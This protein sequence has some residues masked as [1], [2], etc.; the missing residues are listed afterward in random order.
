MT[1]RPLRVLLAGF[2]GVGRE[3]ARILDRRSDHPGLAGADL[4]LVAITTGRHGALAEPRGIDPAEALAAY[5]RGGF[6]PGDPGFVALDTARAVADLDYDVLVDASPLRIPERGEPAISWLRTALGRGHHAVTCNKGPVAWAHREL[7]TLAR[8]RGAAFRFESTVMDGVPVFHLARCGL[9]GATVERLEGILNSTTNVVL[10]G[11][12]AGLDL[13][14][15]VAGAQ[16]MG[17]AEADPAADLEGWDAAVKLAALA[18]ALLVGEGEAELLP[19]AVS[20]EAVDEETGKRAREAAARG[21]RLKM[22]CEVGR[23]GGAGWG[24]EG[25]LRARVEARV[26]PA[27]HPFARVDGASSIL[28]FTADLPGTF[29]LIEE[30]PDLTTTAYGLI[31]DLLSLPQTP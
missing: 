4:S 19:E 8:E 21:E 27:H 9:R 5:A 12:E 3:L 25:P 28:R 11:L 30:D 29:T 23:G 20:R 16:D 1:G 24:R 7:A 6:A 10:G 22:V 2:G 18:N 15:A 31:S 17:I 26:L 13:A 14:A